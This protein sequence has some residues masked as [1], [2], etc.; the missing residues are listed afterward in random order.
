MTTFIRENNGRDALLVGTGLALVWVV[1]A[2]IRPGA[3]FHLAPVLVAGSIPM[4]TATTA[5]ADYAK[6]ALLGIAVALLTTSA[7]AP[8]DLLR[9]PSLLPIGGAA[10]EAVVFAVGGAILAFTIATLRR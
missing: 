8:L 3:T 1:A 6:A 4:L 10:L 5:T 2:T 7:L 9:G